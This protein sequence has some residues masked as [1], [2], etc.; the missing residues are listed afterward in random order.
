MRSVWL[1]DALEW[2][3]MSYG[4]EIWGWKE[5]GVERIQERF[6]KWILDLKGRTPGYL[7]TEE[8]QRGKLRERTGERAGRFEERLLRGEGS[9]LARLC[10]KELRDNVWR[11]RVGSR[12]EEERPVSR[13]EKDESTGMGGEKVGGERN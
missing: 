7:V 3:V 1:F 6:L 12:W 2:T 11:D 5:R 9:E 10:L 4:V 8:M 13:G